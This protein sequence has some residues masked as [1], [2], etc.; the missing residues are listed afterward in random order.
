MYDTNPA[1][2]TD[3]KETLE[4]KTERRSKDGNLFVRGVKNCLSMV[5]TGRRRRMVADKAVE[6]VAEV[7]RVSKR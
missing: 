6:M 7:E 5:E 2:P 4:T 3:G 1:F